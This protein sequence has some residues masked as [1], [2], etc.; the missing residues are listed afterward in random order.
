MA[1]D[2]SQSK[3]SELDR[4][5]RLPILEG[6]SIDEDVEDDSVRLD[7]SAT[8]PG[9]TV[10]T[11]PPPGDYRPS[12]LD[13]PSL[14]ESVRSVE[15]RIARQNADYEAL[16][17]LYERARDAQLA[18]GTRADELASELGAAHSA[19]AVEQ[20]RA[21]ELQAA[22]AERNAASEQTRAR[23]R[24]GRCAKRWFPATQPLR[25]CCIRWASAMLSS[26]P[27]SASTPKWFPISRRARRRARCSIARSRRPRSKRRRL[28]S[29]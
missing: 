29:N 28:P 19:L 11:A 5:D 4:T 26:P 1:F 15:E 7:Y 21:R 2:K 17:R 27:C 18:A 6:I 14:A 12:A 13:L 16:N 9:T 10:V 3:E 20:H 8:M 22:L 25:R 24:R 23:A